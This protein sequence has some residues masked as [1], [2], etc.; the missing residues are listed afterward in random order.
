MRFITDTTNLTLCPWCPCGSLCRKGDESN[1]LLEPAPK[2]ERASCSC[3]FNRWFSSLRDRN[4]LHMIHMYIYILSQFD[5][6]FFLNQMIS[7]FLLIYLFI[8][9]C[10]SNSFFASSSNCFCLVTLSFKKFNRE[11]VL[12][13][14]N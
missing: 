11:N 13:C 5:L 14:W 10:R 7:L 12:V 1:L 3:A 4:S 2:L 9:F 8:S 6:K